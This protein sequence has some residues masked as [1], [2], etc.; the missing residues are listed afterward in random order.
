L[1]LIPAFVPEIVIVSSVKYCPT[2]GGPETVRLFGLN[3]IR[4]SLHSRLIG[5]PTAI[6]L[7]SI[8]NL[9]LR[10]LFGVIVILFGTKENSLI[11]YIEVSFFT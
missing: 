10:S 11:G 8:N 3:F 7:V 4:P 1:A 5:V 6:K 9:I 2:F